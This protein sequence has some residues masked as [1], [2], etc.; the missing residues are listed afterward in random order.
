M[1]RPS[2]YF[3]NPYCLEQENPAEYQQDLDH[4]SRE[5]LQNTYEFITR[6]DER[7]TNGELYVGAPGIAYAFYHASQVL[8]TYLHDQYLQLAQQYIQSSLSQLNNSKKGTLKPGL[9]CGNGGIIAVASVIL[10]KIGNEILSNNFAQQYADLSET[11]K[12]PNSMRNGSDEFFVGRAGYLY[13]AI[14]MNKKLGR[15]IVSNETM[16]D[17]ANLIV[18]SGK[19]YS[20]ETRCPCPLMYAYYG[21]EY[22]GAAHGISSILQTLL[23]VRE[24]IYFAHKKVLLIS[25]ESTFNYHMLEIFV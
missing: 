10:S 5:L 22:L 19:K 11:C 12:I 16:H 14:W 25:N 2:R 9:L 4:V 20:D 18:E 8:P 3:V 21:T 23:Q 24:K 6:A 15:Q 7:D 13:G 17:I 1:S